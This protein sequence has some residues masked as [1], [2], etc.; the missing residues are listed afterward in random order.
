MDRFLLC[1][2][3]RNTNG[4]FGLFEAPTP[5]GPWQ[6]VSYVEDFDTFKPPEPNSRVCTHH[7]APKWWRNGGQT[8]TM[9]FNVGDDSWN[10]IHGELI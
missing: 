9:V 6:V 2:S 3:H 7:F 4:N 5:W 10:T 8:F 1:Y